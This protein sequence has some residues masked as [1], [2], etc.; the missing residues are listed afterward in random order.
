MTRLRH[1]GCNRKVTR[2]FFNK[3]FIFFKHK[4]CPLQISSLSQLHAMETFFP[5]L[6]AALEVFN[7]CGF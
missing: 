7:G 2:P 1:T 4:C 6:V 3:V 5:L